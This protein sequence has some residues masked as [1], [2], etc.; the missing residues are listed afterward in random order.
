MTTASKLLQMALSR[1][2]YYIVVEEWNYPTESG[3]ELV[4]DYDTMAQALNAAKRKCEVEKF[5]YSEATGCDPLVGEV[6]VAENGNMRKRG[7]CITDKKGV[8]DFWY[9]AKIIEVFH[10]IDE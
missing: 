10:G 2:R 4:G 7:Y 5:C 8:E 1:P 3:R 9:H 6:C